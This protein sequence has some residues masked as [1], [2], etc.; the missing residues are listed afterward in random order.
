MLRPRGIGFALHR[1]F[2]GVNNNQELGGRFHLHLVP[3]ALLLFSS[4]KRMGIVRNNVF[5]SGR[6]NVK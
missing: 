6:G 1:A 4:T 3:Y 5:V 2:H